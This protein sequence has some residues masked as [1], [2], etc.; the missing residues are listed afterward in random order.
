MSLI[1]ISFIIW[2][3]SVFNKILKINNTD[4]RRVFIFKALS[5]LVSSRNLHE[6][7]KALKKAIKTEMF[8]INAILI[9]VLSLYKIKKLCVWK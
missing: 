6:K 7:I 1:Y 3:V 2:S 8:D 4:N 9:A 5:P